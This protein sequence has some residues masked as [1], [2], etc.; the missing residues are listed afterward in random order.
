MAARAGATVRSV[1][2]SH[3]VFVANPQAVAELIEQ[4][5]RETSGR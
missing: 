5:A 2:G 1:P 4:A 3:A